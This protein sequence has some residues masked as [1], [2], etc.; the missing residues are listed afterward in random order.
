MISLLDYC[1]D[2]ENV[3]IFYAG[4]GSPTGQE[5]VSGHPH[6]D[7]ATRLGFDDL[8]GEVDAEGDWHWDG[9]GTPRDSRRNTITK[10]QAYV[11]E[12]RYAAIVDEYENG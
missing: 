12:K 7:E 11:S 3:V 6:L 1:N 5:T 8:T 2:R 4:I 10:V 9:Q